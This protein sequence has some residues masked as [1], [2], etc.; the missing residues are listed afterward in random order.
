MHQSAYTQKVLE[1]FGLDKAYTTK[2]PIIA[3]SLQQD[4]DPYRP[5]KEREETL[6]PEFPYLSAIG[7][8]MYLIN[9]TWSDIAFAV[10]LLACYGSE[11][12]KRQWKCL[13]DI[14]WYLQGTKD[15]GLFFKKNQDMSLLGYAD[16]RYFSDSHT[17]KS[18]TGFIFLC[19]GTV[20]SL[21]SLK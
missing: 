9:Y 20:I 5:R 14:F 6:W 11:P 12:T 16:A 21:K 3:R 4:Q 19:G 8:I 1:K 15:F 18:Q 17:S 13:K 10:N 2:T 7:A